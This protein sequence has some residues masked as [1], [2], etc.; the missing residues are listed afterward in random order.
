M[1]E[2]RENKT[3]FWLSD[4]A[5]FEWGERMTV[6]RGGD[7]LDDDDDDNDDVSSS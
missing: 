5:C 6:F 3:G 1:K 2:R 7:K 4:T